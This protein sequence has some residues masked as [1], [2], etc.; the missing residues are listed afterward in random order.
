MNEFLFILALFLFAGGIFWT[1]KYLQYRKIEKYTMGFFSI[2]NSALAVS[3]LL[4]LV[5]FTIIID[6]CFG[7]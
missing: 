6:Y 1:F 2:A 3:L 5:S 7:H 4:Y